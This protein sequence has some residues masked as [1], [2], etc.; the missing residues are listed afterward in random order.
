ML[1]KVLTEFFNYFGAVLSYIVIAI[2]IF[3]GKKIIFEVVYP[4]M[5]LVSKSQISSARSLSLSLL[6]SLSSISRTHE[7]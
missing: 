5:I 2:P 6:P 7:R 1:L 3:T 4:Q